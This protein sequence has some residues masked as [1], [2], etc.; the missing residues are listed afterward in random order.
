MQKSNLINPNQQS[1][2]TN[3]SSE[4]SESGNVSINK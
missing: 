4:P 1:E 3:E 2:V